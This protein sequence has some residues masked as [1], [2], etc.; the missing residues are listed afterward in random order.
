VLG[1]FKAPD[2]L[3]RVGGS[4]YKETPSSGQ[5]TLGAPATA[6]RGSIAAGALEQSNVDVA[7]EF[8]RMIAA[9]RSFQANSKTLTTADQLLAELMTLRR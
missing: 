7:S 1:N 4:L 8:I 9:Q 3:A 5:G 2:Q 6:D